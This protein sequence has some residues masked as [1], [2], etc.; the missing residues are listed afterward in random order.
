ML[1]GFTT[2][3]FKNQLPVTP[4]SQAAL[5]LGRFTPWGDKPIPRQLA[6][7]RSDV[8]LLSGLSRATERRRMRCEQ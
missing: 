6:A 7:F 1:L 2:T 3:P 4:G 8:S 5:T